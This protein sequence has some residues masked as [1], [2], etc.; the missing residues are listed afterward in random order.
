MDPHEFQQ[1][2]FDKRKK[3]VQ[4]NK[5]FFFPPTNRSGT[6]TWHPHAKE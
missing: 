2:I 6:T 4:W 3:A 5:Y 1:L